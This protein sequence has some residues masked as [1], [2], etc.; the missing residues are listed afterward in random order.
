MEKVKVKKVKA[1]KVVKVVCAEGSSGIHMR[2]QM[3]QQ[4][5]CSPSL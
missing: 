2:L 5:A 4:P 1:V 3:L